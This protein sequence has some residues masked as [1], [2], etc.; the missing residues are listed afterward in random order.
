MSNIDKAARVIHEWLQ[1]RFYISQ[2]TG[3]PRAIAQRIADAGL[4]AAEQHLGRKAIGFEIVP[5]YA[6]HA[7]ELLTTDTQ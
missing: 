2:D 5:E 6:H 3:D 4:L 7:A 1:E